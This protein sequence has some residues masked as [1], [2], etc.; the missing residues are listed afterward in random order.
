MGRI[1]PCDGSR[2]PASN[3]ADE[4]GVIT[5]LHVFEYDGGNIN[6][7][8]FGS[9]GAEFSVVGFRVRQARDRQRPFVALFMMLREIAVAAFACNNGPK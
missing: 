4:F 8:L 2:F 7:I 9:F 3:G 1:S 5:D 6:L